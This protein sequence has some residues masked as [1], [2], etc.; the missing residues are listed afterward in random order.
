MRDRLK[1]TRP[2]LATASGVPLW[3][4]EAFEDGQE[5]PLVLASFKNDLRLALEIRSKYFRSLPN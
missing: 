1:W 2:R 5:I 3:Y 4:L